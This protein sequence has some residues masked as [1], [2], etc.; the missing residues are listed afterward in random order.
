MNLWW[1][2]KNFPPLS[3][4]HTWHSAMTSHSPWSFCCQ[5]PN[6]NFSCYFSYPSPVSTVCWA[7]AFLNTHSDTQRHCLHF[8][9]EQLI[10]FST[11]W[12]LPFGFWVQTT[13][14]YSLILVS[15]HICSIYSTLTRISLFCSV[16][17]L[18]KICMHQNS[19]MIRRVEKELRELCLIS[20]Q[21]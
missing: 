17:N 13:A 7:L 9:L 1:Q 10:P 3:L 18:K 6:R 15:S 16:F 2:K 5:C 4:G 12:S 11:L 19:K 21:R 20:Q 14:A 8:P